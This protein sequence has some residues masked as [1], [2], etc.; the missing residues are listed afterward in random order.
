MTALN[1]KVTIAPTKLGPAG[2]AWSVDLD[3]AL[4]AAG[5]ARADDATLSVWI[6]EAAW[7]HP[8]WH[9]YAIILV[10]LRPM[11]DGRETKLYRADASHEFWVYALNPEKPREAMIRTGRAQW[12]T[13]INFAAQLAEASDQAAITRIEGAIDLIL[14]GELSPD[15]DFQ[16]QWEAL[17]GNAM[18]KPGARRT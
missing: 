5:F 1:D 6:V 15:T 16:H 14:T 18:I 7:A 13:P 4:L 9:S 8:L 12:L 17:F 3:T 2:R 10:H 11:P